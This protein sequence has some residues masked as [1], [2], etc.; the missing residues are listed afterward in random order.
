MPLIQNLGHWM[1]VVMSTA[2]Q[3]NIS[4]PS[5]SHVA[6]RTVVRQEANGDSSSGST[7]SADMDL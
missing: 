2:K 3:A 1:R 4:T 5:Y 6:Y 7:K